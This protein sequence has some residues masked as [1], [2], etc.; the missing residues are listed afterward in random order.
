M[1]DDRVKF[2]EVDIDLLLMRL[3]SD[4]PAGYNYKVLRQAAAVIRFLME[5]S[6]A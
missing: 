2:D 6:D 1:S 4:Y 5:D 3:E